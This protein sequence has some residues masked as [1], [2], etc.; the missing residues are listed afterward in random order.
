MR[1]FACHAQ[2]HSDW[3]NFAG[4]SPDGARVVTA[5]DDNTVRIW[6]AECLAAI[7]LSHL[8]RLPMGECGAPI[9]IA[10]FHSF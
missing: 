8:S 5:S 7:F 1:D 2:G 4:F 3:I 9:E 6:N 10:G